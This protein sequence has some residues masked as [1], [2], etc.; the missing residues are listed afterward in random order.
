ML[1]QNWNEFAA[2]LAMFARRNLSSVARGALM[3]PFPAEN[4]MFVVVFGRG[5][6]Q[7]DADTRG[8]VGAVRQNLKQIPYEELGFGFSEDGTT[9]ALLGE[10]AQR[11]LQTGAGQEFQREM[12][13]A[14]LEE[15]VWG[16]AGEVGPDHSEASLRRVFRGG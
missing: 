6:F 7:N 3:I 5:D 16:T 2:V 11:P 12:L 1:V 14:F 10:A 15:A 9:W 8:R 13:R 4:R